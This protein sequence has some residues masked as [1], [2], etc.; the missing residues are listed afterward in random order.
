MVNN[1]LFGEV[2]MKKFKFLSL[3]LAMVML[4]A[5]VVGCKDKN[6]DKTGDSATNQTDGYDEIQFDDD[7]EEDDDDIVVDFETG[8]VIITPSGDKTDGDTSSDAASSDEEETSSVTSSDSSSSKNESS[9][10]DDDK[11]NTSSTDPSKETMDGWTPW[12]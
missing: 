10:P 1:R 11:T 7:E 9:K 2:F 3:I 6:S 4:L 8:E 12:Q 5:F